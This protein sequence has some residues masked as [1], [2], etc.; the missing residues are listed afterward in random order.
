MAS[1]PTPLAS[2]PTPAGQGLLE[3][4]II[5]LVLTWVTVVAR[6]FTRY[7]INALGLDDWFMIA[8]LVS[9]LLHTTSFATANNLHHQICFT[10]TCILVILS[11][12]HGAGARAAALSAYNN[13]QGRKVSAPPQENRRPS[14]L[15]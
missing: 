2:I 7:K 5:L 14:L 4:I 13:V 3:L 8:G 10:V 12:Y 6:T 15:S 1:N 11:I 9:G